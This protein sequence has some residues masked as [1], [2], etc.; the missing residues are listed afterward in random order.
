MI[1]AY[2]E[3]ARNGNHS[4]GQENGVLCVCV[5]LFCFA[6][7]FGLKYWEWNVASIRREFQPT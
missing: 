3:Y 4:L 2:E 7:L 6:L 1:A 5:C